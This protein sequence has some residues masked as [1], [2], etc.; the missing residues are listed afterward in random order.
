M[1]RVLGMLDAGVAPTVADLEEAEALTRCAH[2]RSFEL[3]VDRWRIAVVLEQ[4]GRLT[5]TAPAPAHV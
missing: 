5:E 3:A 1:D 4:L 2:P